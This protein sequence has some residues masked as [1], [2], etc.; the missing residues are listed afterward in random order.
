MRSGRPQGPDVCHGDGGDARHRR[1]AQDPAPGSV[2]DDHAGR[3]R[4]RAGVDQSTFGLEAGRLPVPQP[5]PMNRP[6]RTRQYARNPWAL[7]RRAGTR[8]RRTRHTPMR[9]TKATLIYRRAKEPPGRATAQPRA[10]QS[11]TMFR[12]Q[13]TSR[14]AGRGAA[15]LVPWHEATQCGTYSNVLPGTTARKGERLGAAPGERAAA[16][17][18]PPPARIRCPDHLP[19]FVELTS[20]SA[21]RVLAVVHVEASARRGVRPLV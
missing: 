8:P 13:P 17:P 15:L 1:P 4:R 12:R 2:R 19:R 3:P 14:L 7:G 5:V 10:F 21:V 6:I 11:W 9:R 16:S 18:R 20:R